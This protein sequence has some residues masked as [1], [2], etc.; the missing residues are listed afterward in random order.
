MSELSVRYGGGPLDARGLFIRAC[1]WLQRQ[2]IAFVDEPAAVGPVLAASVHKGRFVEE[3]LACPAW[4]PVRSVESVDGPEWEALSAQFREV[5]K[6]LS[7]RERLPAAVQR[8]MQRLQQQLAADPTAIVDAERVARVTAAA[9]HEVIFDS[10]PTEAVEDLLYAASMEWRK[11]IAIKGM[12]APSVK[13]DFVDWLHDA[14]QHSRW[15]D[16]LVDAPDPNRVVSVFA[17]P[18]LLSPQI[19]VCD[20]LVSVF[21]ALEADPELD[22][23]AR[24]WAS[25]RDTAHLQ[26][27]FLEAIRL[28]HPFPV[29][30]RWLPRDV[31][32]GGQRLKSGTQVFLLLDALKQDRAFLPERWLAPRRENP[33]ADIPFGAGGRMCTGKP[34]ATLLLTELLV[35]LLGMLPAAQVRPG[36]GHRYSGRHNDGNDDSLL[37]QLRTFSRVLLESAI[38]G[39]KGDGKC[40]FH[41]AA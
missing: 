5:F 24:K 34:L 28:A 15:A 10:P 12:G 19:N 36:V 1:A 16:L 39:V 25:S 41:R 31:D 13:R 6:R 22:I 17:Q 20:I 4:E 9:L 33:Y 23:R 3:R 30:E 35:G 26:G 14:L 32:I 40:P 38:M 7:W 27:L 2:P 18:L 29:L 8:Q 11:E 37:H 21:S